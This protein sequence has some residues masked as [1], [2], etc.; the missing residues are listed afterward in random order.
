[1]EFEPDAESESNPTCSAGRR[2]AVSRTKSCNAGRRPAVP[3]DAGQRFKDISIQSRGYLPHWELE[4]A[5]YFITYRLADSLPKSVLD[6][7][8]YEKI[9][10]I[11]KLISSG[12]KISPAQKK[13][14]MNL[15]SKSIDDNLDS[16]LGSCVLKYP[17]AAAIVQ[18]N[19]HHF[20]GKKYRLFAWCI[21]PNHVH[22]VIRPLVNHGLCEILY[23][24]KSFTSK[25]INKMLERD[26]RLWQPER[27]DRII[28]G[29]NEF[30]RVIDY[31]MKN[32]A[33]AG[34]PEWKWTWW[35]GES[36]KFYGF[37]TPPMVLSRYSS[38]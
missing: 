23:S 17:K 4:G 33:K 38:T 18:E 35:F 34:L 9:M 1:M 8:E 16:G 22:V 36:N 27:Y 31:V 25:S 26:G 12:K 6:H 10:K 13:R 5:V 19:L 37:P 30:W 24:W 21:M 15:F 29:E 3:L 2:P 7:I 14:I 20:D 32:P 28:R 11:N